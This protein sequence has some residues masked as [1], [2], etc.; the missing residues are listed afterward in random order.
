MTPKFPH[1]WILPRPQ[2][3]PP[4]SAPSV[5]TQRRPPAS[6]PSF[7]YTTDPGFG[8]GPGE[9]GAPIE[10]ACR[11]ALLGLPI[12]RAPAQIRGQSGIGR[13]PLARP[14][15]RSCDPLAAFL[16]RY[17]SF[18][19]AAEVP[20]PPPRSPPPLP[21]APPGRA[22]GGLGL[23]GWRAGCPPVLLQSPGALPGPPQRRCQS[24]IP[25]LR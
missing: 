9:W 5:A 2:R 1:F 14:A 16:G 22:P 10:R 20:S 19:A 18:F 7:Q 21:P 23:A 11:P 24:H 25:G 6:A 3:R 4:A 15:A 8:L 13:V 17:G 12:L